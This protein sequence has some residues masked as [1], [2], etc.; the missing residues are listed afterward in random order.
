VK[1]TLRALMTDEGAKLVNESGGERRAMN[2][3]ER[4]HHQCDG[5]REC[6]DRQEYRRHNRPFSSSRFFGFCF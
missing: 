6:T 5:P 1:R 4:R 3:D 2:K